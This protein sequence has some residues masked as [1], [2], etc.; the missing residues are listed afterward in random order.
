M[1]KKQIM[2]FLRKQESPTQHYSTKKRD[3]RFREHDMKLLLLY[4]QKKTGTAPTARMLC[5]I[6]YS[7]RYFTPMGCSLGWR[8]RKAL[9]PPYEGGGVFAFFTKMTEDDLNTRILT[10][11]HLKA[12]MSFLRKQ[13]SPT[14]PGTTKTRCPFTP[15]C[16]SSRA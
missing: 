5:F 7:Y 12:I 16:T 14:Q 10:F 13:E 11:C 3:A 15:R 4:Y 1:A 8:R 6:S 9:H 2:S